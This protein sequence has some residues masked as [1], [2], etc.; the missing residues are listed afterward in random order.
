MSSD[1]IT[2][3]LNW[4]PTAY[5]IPIYLAQTRGYFKEQGIR[6]AILEPSNPSEVTELIGT[7][8]IDMG[9]KAMIHTLAAK[10]RG[11][12]VTSVGSLLDEP[13]TGVLYL[14]G[15]G[16]TPDFKSLKGKK[17]GYVGEFGKIQIDELTKHYGMTPDDYTAV[18]CGMNVAKY[19]IEGK[20]D[21]GVGIECIQQ[22]E[23]EEYLKAQGR[24]KEDAQML[25]IDKLA[26]LGC[27][28]F[29]TILYI[30]NDEF[31]AAN[32]EKVR[33]F[34]NA[35]KKAT[36]YFLENPKDAWNEYCDFKPQMKT[37]INTKKFERCFAYFSE[38]LYNV[39]R[40]W[41][42]VTAY[43]KRLEILPKDY[44]PNYSN[45][46]LSWEEPKEVEDPLK[47]QALMAAHQEECRSCGGCRR[48][49][50]TGI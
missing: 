48:L 22:V 7:G 36:D 31:L 35:I 11:Y 43:G 3:L 41:R 8:K 15:S 9:L 28:C 23:L 38:S 12:P 46:Y 1:L 21:A 49:C 19:I 16:I 50:L 17:I 4:E 2:F 33:K 42:K 6:V 5:H 45:E 14:K 30:A 39:H 13:F 10:A 40:D 29:C 26:E 32:P 44:Q 34:L 27:C 20:I 37:A 25:R 47:A 18:R 24:P